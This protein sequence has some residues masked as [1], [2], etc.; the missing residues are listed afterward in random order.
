M[1]ADAERAERRIAYLLRALT[2]IAAA[3]KEGATAARCSDLAQRALAV[4]A[5]IAASSGQGAGS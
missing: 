1:T 4:D 5:V 2:R 3:S